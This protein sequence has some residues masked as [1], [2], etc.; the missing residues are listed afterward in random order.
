MSRRSNVKLRSHVRDTWI[1]Y[2]KEPHPYEDWSL[3]IQKD[4]DYRFFVGLPPKDNV[5]KDG[6][7]MNEHGE[8]EKDKDKL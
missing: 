5:N 7:I 4:V 6:K 1:R 2:L 8:V 3:D